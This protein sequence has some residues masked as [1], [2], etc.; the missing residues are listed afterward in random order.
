M[1]MSEPVESFVAKRHAKRY[2][3]E[4]DDC[5]SC[6]LLNGSLIVG[7]GIF[8]GIQAYRQKNNTKTEQYMKIAM[9][10]VGLGEC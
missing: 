4:G 6:R 2:I 5:Q 3:E 10:G 7:A 8:V 9:S 1:K